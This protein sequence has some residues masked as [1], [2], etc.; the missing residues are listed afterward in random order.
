MPL[1]GTGSRPRPTRT[2]A[3]AVSLLVHGALVAVLFRAA[4]PERGSAPGEIE[5]ELVASP[6]PHPVSPPPATA[7]PDPVGPPLPR[8]LPAPRRERANGT[9]EAPAR[10]G[11][12][13]DTTPA[14]A[15]V[16]APAAPP[17][18][19]PTAGVAPVDPGGLRMR[20][21]NLT[22]DHAT[23]DRFSREGVIAPTPAGP[24]AAPGRRDAGEGKSKWQQKLALIERADRARGNVDSGQVHPQIYDFM[25][26]AK[27]LFS[28]RESVV[29][30]DD[31]V[32]GSLQRALK[33]SFSGY[34]DQ[35]RS[36]ERSQPSRRGPLASGGSDVLG[37]Y[38]RLLRAAEKGAEAIS[39]QVCLVLRP[40]AAP[41][42]V[43]AGSSGNREVDEAAT[44]ALTR[45]ASRRPPDPDLV[46]QRAC[47]RFA[48]R[49]WRVPP[50]P[51][52]GCSFDEATLSARCF[53]PG[54]QIYRLN[55]NLE[56]VD[57][58]SDPGGG[59]GGAGR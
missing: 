27:R 37:E 45:A 48:A 12:A 23:L 16:A 46:F 21:P 11:T 28:P 36:L 17:V 33:Q 29:E 9:P 19:P 31:R 41:E 2:W 44:D 56:L 25:R 6:A 34:L 59:D 13:P 55:V 10:T 15:P 1:A 3:A 7:A 26:D 47:Y 24:P 5:I 52:A 50:L 22:L 53:Y 30:R 39:C 51:I 58:T 38:D 42:V 18:A 4:P 20:G 40:G 54:K 32:P 57:Y 35:L 49:I 43:L 8:D 14:P